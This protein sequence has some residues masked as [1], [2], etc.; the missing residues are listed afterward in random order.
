M[1][2]KAPLFRQVLKIIS[3][4]FAAVDVREKNPQ[5][6]Q[7]RRSVD[8]VFEILLCYFSPAKT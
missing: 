3:R 7:S 5:R 1:C 6:R 4:G 2:G 8:Y